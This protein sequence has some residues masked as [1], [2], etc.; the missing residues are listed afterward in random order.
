[1]KAFRPVPTKSSVLA[2]LKKNIPITA[3]VDVGVNEKTGELIKNFPRL[4]HYL[5][6][7]VTLYGGS[8]ERNYS[9]INYELF[10]LALADENSEIFLIVTSLM[11]NGIATHSRISTDKVQVDG[12]AIVSCLPVKVCRF[13]DLDIARAIAE[14]Y[15]LKVDVDGK[16]LDVIKGFG[17]NLCKASA[18]IIECTY[19]SMVERIS[20]IQN[21]GFTLADMVDITYYGDMLFQF[22]AV[23][24]R[25]DL[26][27]LD[28]NPS[29]A[30]FRHDLWYPLRFKSMREYLF[31][32]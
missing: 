18:V 1:M 22:D 31:W 21:M 5:F 14:N 27:T 19:E 6:E 32:W 25:N 13:E 12:L 9:K 24:V 10:P 3:I 29:K 26:V 17:P 8:I 28:L 7:P 15:L 20:Y 2:R 23:L 30:D 16:D 11:K 4:K